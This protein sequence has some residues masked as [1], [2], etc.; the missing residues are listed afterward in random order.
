MTKQV[1][2]LGSK[3]KDKLR[4]TLNLWKINSTWPTGERGLNGLQRTTG[5]RAR[6]QAESG[7]GWHLVFDKPTLSVRAHERL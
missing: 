5:G 7:R 1:V 2:V 4:V 6:P 3:E